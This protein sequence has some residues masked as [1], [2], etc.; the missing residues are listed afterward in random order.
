MVMSLVTVPDVHNT[1]EGRPLTARLEVNSQLLALVTWA[2]RV[3]GPPAE[4]SDEGAASKAATVGG[5]AAATV[6]LIGLALAVLEPTTD[7]WK[8]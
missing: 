1:V 8:V 2:D 5:R 6:S 7:R 3:T 4:P